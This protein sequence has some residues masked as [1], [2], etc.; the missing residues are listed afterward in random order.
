M[1]M[2]AVD[3][4]GD[5]KECRGM[6]ASRVPGCMLNISLEL[7]GLFSFADFPGKSLE[8]LT[9]D[10]RGMAVE[11]DRKGILYDPELVEKPIGL[12]QRDTGQPLGYAFINGYRCFP[13]PNISDSVGRGQARLQDRNHHLA[14]S[15]QGSESDI[16][17]PKHLVGVE[18]TGG[19]RTEE[20][21]FRS[22]GE[23]ESGKS[24]QGVP[25]Q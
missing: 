8:H 22:G 12:N 11:S 24:G 2:G 3:H 20:N 7:V 10:L 25:G 21:G 23:D 16:L 17:E 13:P 6:I 1:A 14:Q 5:G 18:L 15:F 19:I 9:A 4:G